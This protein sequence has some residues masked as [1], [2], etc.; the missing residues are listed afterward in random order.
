MTLPRGTHT[1]TVSPA[2]GDPAPAGLQGASI[3]AGRSPS[4]GGTLPAQPVGSHSEAVLSRVGDGVRSS[5]M[6]VLVPAR[7]RAQPVT[8]PSVD[9]REAR[10]AAHPDPPW[11]AE[12]S[13]IVL[14][15]Q[16]LS[17]TIAR[18][19]ELAQQTIPGAV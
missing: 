5:R 6:P 9:C 18:V 19:A 17:Q 12:L 1:V 16:P 8:P 14:G 11:I 13:K 10:T 2:G 4:A 15:A 7:A 3:R